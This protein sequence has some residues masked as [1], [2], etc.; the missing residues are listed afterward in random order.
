MAFSVA[1]IPGRSTPDALGIVMQADHA[2]LGSQGVSEGTTIYDGDRLSTAAE[3]SLELRMGQAI[4]YIK[5]QSSVIIHSDGNKEAKEIEVELV[6]GAVALAV[7]PTT[8]A[9]I[10][11]SSARV[12]PAAETRGIVQVRLVGPLELLVYAQRGSAEISYHGARETVP[13]GKSYRV[14]LNPLEDGAA[15]VAG[16]SRSGKRDKALLLAAVAG[17][18]AAVIATVPEN[19]G[20]QKSVESPDRP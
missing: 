6:A 3:G 12:R 13:E 20:K 14:L 8:R 5:E 15:G 10:V 11:A 7:P 18:A 17:A 4:L 19:K 2:T 1:G 16:T 9:E